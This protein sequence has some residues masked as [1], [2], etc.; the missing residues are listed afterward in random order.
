MRLLLAA[1]LILVSQASFATSLPF[2]ENHEMTPYWPDQ[3]PNPKFK[4]AQVS[5][6]KAIN[7]DG[8]NIDLN[9][10]KGHVTLVN[11]FFVKCPGICPAMMHSVQKIE[12]AL[13]QE[14]GNIQIYSFSVMPETDTP[15]KLKDY[16]SKYHINGKKWLLLTGQKDVIYHVGKDMFKADGAVGPQKSKDSFIHTQN[17][18]LVDQDLYIRGIYNTGN[19]AEM[20]NI[21]GD[22]ESL[23]AAKLN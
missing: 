13:A 12:K 9:S 10:M 15:D 6:F 23:N 17:L 7:Q 1:I 21:K 11:F 19:A 18:Y 8:K 5:D 3:K 20:K 16:A 22:I 2:Y 14:I 4:P